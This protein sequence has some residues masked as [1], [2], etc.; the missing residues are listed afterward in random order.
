MLA[1]SISMG[2]FVFCMIIGMAL[3]VAFSGGVKFG[4]GMFGFLMF[5]GCF[6]G[7]IGGVGM[8]CAML[9]FYESKTPKETAEETWQ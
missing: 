6:V 7:L 3:F 8:T 2:V 4:T 1:K 9:D 5:V